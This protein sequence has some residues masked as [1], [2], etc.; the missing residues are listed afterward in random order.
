MAMAALPAG[1]PARAALRDRAIV[2][3]LPMAR[4]LAVRYSGRGVPIDDLVQTAAVGLI[5]AV[6][7]FDPDFG[8]DFVGFAIPTVLGE[9]KR[10]FR[11]RTWMIRVP[12][13]LQELRLAINTANEELTHRLHRPPT[14]AQIAAHLDITDEAVL[15]AVEGARAYSALSL[16]ISVSSGE[17]A[18]LGDA[19]GEVDQA[20]ALADARIVIIPALT[21]LDERERRILTLRFYGNLTQAAIAQQVGVSQMHVSRLITRAL[22]HL[23]HELQQDSRTP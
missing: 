5:R 2:A 9:L 15:E 20:F 12:R 18:E 21:R 23:R 19:L 3:W 1:H 22:G 13:R 8:I 10:Y 17:T 6:D 7:R 14:T 4:R 11:D 16:S